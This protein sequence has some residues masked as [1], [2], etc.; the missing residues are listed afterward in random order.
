MLNWQAKVALNL[1]FCKY[2]AGVNSTTRHKAIVE[3]SVINSTAPRSTF[4]NEMPSI[5][6]NAH[7]FISLFLKPYFIMVP[8]EHSFAAINVSRIFSSIS[9]TEVYTY[10]FSRFSQN[11]IFTIM[12]SL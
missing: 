2:F 6:R 12:M 4:Q 11:S 5:L 7:V 10:L 1:L 8:E 3:I 9:K